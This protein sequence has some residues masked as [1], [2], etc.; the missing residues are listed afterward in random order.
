MSLTLDGPAPDAV[1]VLAPPAAASTTGIEAEP[2]PLP[3]PTW[4]LDQALEAV[5]EARLALPLDDVAPEVVSALSTVVTRVGRHA[6]KIYPPGTDPAHLARTAAALTGSTTAL[7]PLAAP[8]VTSTGVVTVMPWV[9]GTGPVTWARTGALLRRFHE[10]HADADVAAWQPLRRL[11]GQ[12]PGLPDEAVG[13]LLDARDALRSA[14]AA[15]TSPLG[16]GVVHGDLNPGNVLRGRRGAVLIDLDWMARAPRE[17]DLGSAA[18][19]FEAGAMDRRTYLSFCRAY[20][21]DVRGWDDRHVLDRVA[22]LGGVAFRL[23]DD[24]RAGRPL[25]WLEDAV[26]RWR[27]PL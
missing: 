25:V 18:R 1:D 17:Y 11:D 3:A 26:A 5:A 20:G 19:R 22:E 8:V 21:A 24:R 15:L 10:E 16:V 4:S 27:T 23:W 7:A 12:L 13:V 14:L 6:V 9:E 2:L